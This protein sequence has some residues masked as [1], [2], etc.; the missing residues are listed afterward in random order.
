MNLVK[1]LFHFCNISVKSSSPI[2]RSV[3]SFYDLTMIL[4]GTLT[5]DINGERTVLCAGDAILL[6]PGTVRARESG[7]TAAYASFNFKI[8]DGESLP[9]ASVMR[10]AV[11]EDTRTLLSVFAEEH[12]SLFYHSKEKAV[13]IL[14]YILLEL[15]D[16]KILPSNNLHIRKALRYIEEHAHESVTLETISAHLHLSKEYTASL[17]KKEL[18]KTVSEYVNEKKMALAKRMIAED[19]YSLHE[20]AEGLGFEHYGYFSRLFKRHFGVSPLGMRQK[21]KRHE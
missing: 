14:N 5:Y 3:I 17:F 10:G 9:L 2:A 6:P 19:T 15:L 1:E 18:G 11:S 21:K 16:F 4:S 13:C 12:V 7:E 8:A 20:I